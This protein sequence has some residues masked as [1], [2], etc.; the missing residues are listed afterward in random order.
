MEKIVYIIAKSKQKI[1]KG[2]NPHKENSKTL[3]EG[4][5]ENLNKHPFLGREYSSS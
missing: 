5:K 2:T 4:H 1:K 3:M